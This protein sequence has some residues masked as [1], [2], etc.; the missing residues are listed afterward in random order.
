MAE[1]L[2]G[3]TAGAFVTPRRF[4]MDQRLDL[5]MLRKNRTPKQMCRL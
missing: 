5:A 4:H 3:V 1:T 2:P